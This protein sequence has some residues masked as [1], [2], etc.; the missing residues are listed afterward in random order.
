[1]GYM[2]FFHAEGAQT[3]IDTA[4]KIVREA[5]DMGY[6][7]FNTGWNYGNVNDPHHNKKILGKA[8]SVISHSVVISSKCGI[9]FDYAANP[10]RPPFIFDFSRDTFRRCAEESLSRLNTDYIDFYLQG[11]VNPKI[12]PEAAAETVHI[13]TPISSRVE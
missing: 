3:D 7:F 6:T 11:R 9:D 4:A 2:G 8:L 13:S 5:A 1:M 10:D 12:S